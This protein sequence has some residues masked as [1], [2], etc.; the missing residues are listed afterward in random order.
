MYKTLLAILFVS[1]TSYSNGKK[2]DKYCNARFSFCIEY[3]RHFKSEPPPE[4]G[5]GLTFISPDKQA[6]V[7]AFGSL[8]VEGFDQIEQKFKISTEDISLTYKV[9][10][11][12][13]F[14]F[15]GKTKDNKVVYRK[16]RKIKINYFGQPGTFVFQTLM[17]EYPFAQAT[18][19]ESYC[20]T[21]SESLK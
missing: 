15:S 7:L 19:Y 1:L 5:D 14:V 10:H 18:I 11:K 6:K 2:Y 13:W 3:P 9:K 20:L 8:A 17:I 12:D 16:T 4:N 21:I